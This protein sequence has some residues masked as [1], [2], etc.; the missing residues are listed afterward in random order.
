M[1]KDTLPMKRARCD[2]LASDR[3]AAAVS[4]AE[5]SAANQAQAADHHRQFVVDAWK[6]GPYI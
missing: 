5:S 6:R 1:L 4:A 2:G 3:S